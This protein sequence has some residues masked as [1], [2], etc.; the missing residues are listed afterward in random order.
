M[1]TLILTL[2]ALCVVAGITVFL[3]MKRRTFKVAESVREHLTLDSLLDKVKYEIIDLVKEE[4]FVGRSDQEWQALY[5]RQKR[6][7]KALRMTVFAIDKYKVIVI[8]M[9][10]TIVARHI[11]T[12]D[13]ATEVLDINS[14]YVP[15]HIK[16]EVLMYYGKKQRGKDALSYLIHKH[17][18]D[19]PRGDIEAGGVSYCIDENDIDSV[20]YKEMKE[21]V[22]FE[23]Q[24][25][26]ISILIYQ[27][28]KG[29]G[30]IDTLQEMN[31]DGLSVGVSGSILTEAAPNADIPRFDRSIW[32]YFEGK[33][34]HLQFLSMYTQEEIRRVTQLISRYN[35][36]GP[37]TEKHPT[38]VTTM[39]NKSRITAVRPSAGESWG[40]FMRK[41]TLSS[42]TLSSLI[43]PLE[44]GP[45]GKPLIIEE[46]LTFDDYCYPDKIEADSYDLEKGM[47]Y[48]SRHIY[49]NAQLAE[50]LIRNMMK[51]QVTTGFTGRQGTGKTTMMTAAIEPVDP[52]LTIRVLELAPEMY[53]RELYP[54]RNIFS[55]QETNYISAAQLQD[56]LKK[57]NAGMSIVG[58]V[59]SDEVAARM[60]QMA[61]VS[62]PFTIF[63][64]HAITTKDLV[65]A[66]TNSIVAAS[67]GAATIDTVMPQVID[68]I[69]MDVHLDFEEGGYRYI[70]RITEIVKKNAEPYP[71]VDP[72]NLEVS[73]AEIE[74]MYYKKTTEREMFETRDIIRFNKDTLT[75]EVVN[76]ISIELLTEM[77]K[78]MPRKEKEEFKAWYTENFK[79]VI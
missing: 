12:Q 44:K 16:F 42:Q 77:C 62:S 53:L 72:D 1:K 48:T 71:E 55:V 32:L 15:A 76:P 19:E 2:I 60:L 79:E 8:D 59:A 50:N 41:F 57:T 63:S 11:Q 30:C 68:A 69:H 17:H 24:L 33:E 10:R 56:F 28:Y 26:I 20:Y 4:N 31:I 52:R 35:N 23:D 64:H 78:R 51:G 27:K 6:R 75:F 61:Q 39:W 38:C 14:L 5:R 7:Q 66:L 13:D 54:S 45:D 74:R 3:Y 43:D 34:I 40:F 18:L 47:K 21:L 29:L 73:K 58:E 70:S 9:I 65:Y 25:D 67:H 36:P 46:E 22:P 37:L 49:H